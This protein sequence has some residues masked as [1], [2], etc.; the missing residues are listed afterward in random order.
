[1]NINEEKPRYVFTLKRN[2]KPYR[3]MARVTVK[4]VKIYLGCFKTQRE[5]V[6]A[7]EKYFANPKPYEKRITS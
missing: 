5:A 7:V 4:F 2:G 1:M 3:Y 6:R